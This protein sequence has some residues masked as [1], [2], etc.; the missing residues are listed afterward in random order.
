M[1]NPAPVLE[2]DT[3]K[4]LW[5]FGIQ[6]DHLIP[7]RRPDLIIINKQKKKTCKIVDFADPADDRIKLKESEKRDKYLNFAREL[8][9]N[10][11]NMK[12]TIIPIVIG[13]FGTVAEGVLKGLEDLEVGGWVE[14]IQTTA[15]L[16]T[17]R[18]LRRVMETWGDLLLLNL[19]WQ[20]ISLRWCEKLL[21]III[22]I[23]ILIVVVIIIIMIIK[24][25]KIKT[26]KTVAERSNKRMG[27]L[28]KHVP[29]LFWNICLSTY[30][31][32]W[33][34]QY[35][36]RKNKCFFFYILSMK[37]KRKNTCIIW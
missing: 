3:H 16:K 22:I 12:V 21:W 28:N 4:L 5:D 37:K 24:I 7:A 17:A 27:N 15:F 34:M 29:H 1:H 18:I 25:I 31:S 30:V 10:L 11:W 32:K 23:I 35:Y 13:A 8:K 20:T 26:L 2:N 14:I 19:L 9:K 36:R 33:N 6:T